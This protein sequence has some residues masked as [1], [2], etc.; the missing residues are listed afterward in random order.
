MTPDEV[1]HATQWLAEELRAR[2]EDV[3]NYDR[4]AHG[5]KWSV[6]H[7]LEHVL[8]DL[9]VYALQVAGQ[10]P[11]AYLPLAGPGGEE[12]VHCDRASGAAGMADSLE[13][14]GE[15]L[16]AALQTRPAT[17]RAYHPYGDADPAGYAALGALEVV[18]HGWDVLTALDDEVADLPEDLCAGVVARLFP[19]SPTEL[20]TAQ[21]VLLW[22]T[23]R[24]ELPGRAR[25]SRW[26][27]SPGV[28]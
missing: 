4:H 22:Q 11:H 26:R 21:E 9:V 15:L 10:V 19:G 23:G 3:V 28:R 2:P 12:L 25:L 17:S 13:A 14:C 5:L 16:A 7:T 20:G 27:P 8:D 1:R 18:V 6:W 24:G